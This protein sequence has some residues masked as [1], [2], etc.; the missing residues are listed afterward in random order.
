MKLDV[1]RYLMSHYTASYGNHL[2]SKQTPG[3]KESRESQQETRIHA[4]SYSMTRE[5]KKCNGIE[6]IYSVH[7]AG[8]TR[9]IHAEK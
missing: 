1:P 5:A 7:G 9:Q 2:A 3:S 8:K 4:V 6:T